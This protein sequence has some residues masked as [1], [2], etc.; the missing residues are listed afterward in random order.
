MTGIDLISSMNSGS[1]PNFDGV[2][3]GRDRMDQ[4][5]TRFGNLVRVTYRVHLEARLRLRFLRPNLAYMDWAERWITSFAQNSSTGGL[6]FDAFLKG[7]S[8]DLLES[9]YQVVEEMN[10]RLSSEGPT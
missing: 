9:I 1:V 10:S 7:K 6:D 2:Y 5:M 3:I 4:L 8:Q